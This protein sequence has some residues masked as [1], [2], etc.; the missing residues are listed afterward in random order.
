M[1]F[2]YPP[3]PLHPHHPPY[4]SHAMLRSSLSLNLYADLSLS[5]SSPFFCQSKYSS[6]HTQ[7]TLHSS[8][9]VG[10]FSYVLI[11]CHLSAP[12][13]NP[14]YH[15]FLPLHLYFPLC[16]RTRV[17][18]THCRQHFFTPTSV[19]PSC[20]L[21]TSFHCITPLFQLK[22]SISSL[23]QSSATSLISVAT[24]NTTQP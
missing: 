6:L 14:T 3:S 24:A 11:I 12:Y 18:F 4:T 21:L 13:V 16:H 9:P 10:L 20:F 15:S 8:P 17:S 2:P 7:F 5:A 19:I 22:T 1:P 23:L